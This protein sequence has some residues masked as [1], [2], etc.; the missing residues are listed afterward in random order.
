MSRLFLYLLKTTTYIPSSVLFFIGMVC[1]LF[2]EVF[3]RD[4]RNITD[5]FNR[6]VAPGRLILFM[7]LLGLS[8]LLLGA[9]FALT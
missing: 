6:F 3:E 1:I 9:F 8:L 5:N 2:P 4:Y 7:R